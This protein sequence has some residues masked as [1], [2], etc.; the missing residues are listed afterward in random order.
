MPPEIV[1]LHIFKPPFWPD[2]DRFYLYGIVSALS[3]E[4]VPSA[5][6][7]VL[8]KIRPD[9]EVR[10]KLGYFSPEEISAEGHPINILNYI[11]NEIETGDG[12]LTSKSS[13]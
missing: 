1:T 13:G 11:D 4:G 5:S 9:D 10:D 7:T 2:P 3:L 8:K 6:K 12:I